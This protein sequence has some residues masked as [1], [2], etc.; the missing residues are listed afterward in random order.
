MIKVPH[1]GWS[2]WWW[3]GDDGSPG[4]RLHRYYGPANLKEWYIYHKGRIK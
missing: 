3:I 4:W 2:S 1:N